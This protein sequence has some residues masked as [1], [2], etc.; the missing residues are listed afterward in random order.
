MISQVIILFILVYSE[1]I[2]SNEYLT[3]SCFFCFLFSFVLLFVLLLGLFLDGVG[4]LFLELLE[5]VHGDL[6]GGGDAG[7]ELVGSSCEAGFAA[8]AAPDAGGDSANLLLS[9]SMRTFPQGGQTYLA[10]C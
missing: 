7:G 8:L 10:L 3:K 2:S 1:N 9:G 6:G 4:E 5:T